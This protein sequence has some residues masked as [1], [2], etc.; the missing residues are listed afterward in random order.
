M[1]RFLMSLFIAEIARVAVEPAVRL[2]LS[3]EV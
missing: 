3:I 1:G 2:S